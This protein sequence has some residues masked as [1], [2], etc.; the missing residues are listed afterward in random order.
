MYAIRSYYGSPSLDRNWYFAPVTGHFFAE[1]VCKKQVTV[2]DDWLD[3]NTTKS[4]D[5]TI[6]LCIGA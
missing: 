1:K 4:G 5:Q 6:N 3:D 2:V